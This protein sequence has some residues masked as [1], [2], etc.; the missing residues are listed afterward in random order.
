MQTA[1]SRLALF[2]SL[3]GASAAAANA[4]A[5]GVKPASDPRLRAPRRETAFLREQLELASGDRFYLRLD[6]RS[7]RLALMLRG[8]ILDEYA[9]LSLQQAVPRIVFFP[10]RPADDWDLR[11]F[12]RGRLEPARAEDRVEVEAPDPAN[13]A[14]PPPPPIPKTAEETYSVPSA[15]RVA[16]AEG[17][18]LEIRTT[19]G[20]G[21]NRSPLRRA[22]DAIGLAISDRGAALRSGA[23]ARVRLRVTLS[24]ADAA[25][26]YRSLPPDVGLVAVGL[27]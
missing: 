10:V 9:V 5:A 2:L 12:S 27:P 20:G 23:R 26:L 7:G 24:P 11:C 16:F 15:F 1:P 8:V 21:R 13:G 3:L 17:P 14:S 18:S 6:A 4:A 19:G 25:A 22:V